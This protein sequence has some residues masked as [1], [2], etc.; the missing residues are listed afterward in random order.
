[1]TIAADWPKVQSNQYRNAQNYKEPGRVLTSLIDSRLIYFYRSRSFESLSSADFSHRLTV[2]LFLS[3][4]ILSLI[5]SFPF[6]MLGLKVSAILA[7]C[8]YMVAGARPPSR[9][10][11]SSSRPAPDLPDCPDGQWFWEAKRICL[12]RLES[13]PGPILNPPNGGICRQMWYWHVNG[14][15]AP[16]SPSNN[17]YRCP[18]G[19]RLNPSNFLCER[20]VV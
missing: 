19:Y 17:T 15:C 9:H 20:K 8:I 16:L 12:P 10:V 6:M 11:A 1:M 5:P 14:Y 2:D 18:R 4:S 3:V 13:T 7:A